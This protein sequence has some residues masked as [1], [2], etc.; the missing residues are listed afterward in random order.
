ML[1]IIKPRTIPFPD[2]PFDKG[3]VYLNLSPI[4]RGKED[5]IYA[6]NIRVVPYRILPDG[7][8]EQNDQQGYSES[9]GDTSEQGK[10]DP[11]IAKAVAILLDAI[12]GFMNDRDV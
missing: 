11:Y 1:F 4:V 10:T 5:P 8:V 3:L 9:I 12:Q 7:S 2:V 6:M